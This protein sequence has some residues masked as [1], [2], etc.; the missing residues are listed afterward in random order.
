M[1]SPLLLCQV[2]SLV[3]FPGTERRSCWPEIAQQGH[4]LNWT[5]YLDVLGCGACSV[6]V[7]T[8]HEVSSIA[9]FHVPCKNNAL[10]LLRAVPEGVF[11]L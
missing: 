6:D 10:L 2:W 11:Q 3:C 4:W 5:E 9:S 1:A 7:D 8:L